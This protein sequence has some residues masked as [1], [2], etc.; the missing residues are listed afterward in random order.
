LSTA[1]LVVAVLAKEWRMMNLL[2][3]INRTKTPEPW[4]EGEKIPWNEPG[5]SKRMLKEHLSQEHDAAS[6]RFEKIDAYVD[7]VHR[8]LLNERPA[9]VLDLGCGP[10]L[11]ASRLARLGHTCKGIDFSPASIAYAREEAQRDGLACTYVEGDIRTTAYGAGFDLALFIYGELNPFRPEDAKAILRKAFDALVDSGVL[12]LEVH[13][14]DS[15]QRWGKQ[16][17]SWHTTHSGLFSDRPHLHLEESFW[18]EERNVVTTRFY[19]VDAE[20]S[21]VTRHAMSTQAYTDE[22]YRALVIGC[23]FSDVNLVI[24]PP[25]AGVEDLFPI[26]ARKGAT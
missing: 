26:V 20:T 24:G 14:F 4:A 11:Y 13:T 7:W 16:R 18:D 21:E 5:F 1:S 15:L 17:H 10:G 23:G 25:L 8:E 3:L 19:T 12:L 22:Q 6:R 2:H 9:R